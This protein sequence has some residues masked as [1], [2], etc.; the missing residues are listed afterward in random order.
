[1]I[2]IGAVVFAT[3]RSLVNDRCYPDAFPQ[4]LA[5]PS[6]P[7][8][9]YQMISLDPVV[10]I[11]GTDDGGTDQT[12]V[13]IDYVALTKGAALLLRHSGRLALM[14]T[15]PPCT[16]AGGFERDDPETKT[17]RVSDDYLFQPSSTL[18]SP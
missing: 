4:P 14:N 5:L 7:A 17:Y 15:D 3:L 2:Y 13:Q 1:M 9:R 10:D 18:G 8:I 16:R 11:K 6:W 12:R